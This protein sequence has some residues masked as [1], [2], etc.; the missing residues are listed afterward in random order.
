MKTGKIKIMKKTN[1]QLIIF[2]ATGDLAS[3]KLFP[4]IC[5][6]YCLKRLPDNFQIIGFGRT[7][8]TQEQFRKI[9]AENVDRKHQGKNDITALLSKHVFYFQGQY[10]DLEDFERLEKFCREIA[11]GRKSD[12]ITYFSVPPLLFEDIAQNLAVTLKRT[13]LDFKVVIEKPF[14]VSEKTAEHLF[15]KISANYDEPKVFLLDHFLG[16]RPIQSILKMR[17]ENNVINLMIKGNEIAKI[18]IEASEKEDVGKRVGYYDQV[19][20]IKDMVQSH[21]LQILALITMDIPASLSLESLQREKQNILSAIRFS[22][23]KE[24]VIIGQYEGY[25]ELKDVTKGSKTETYAA[26]RLNIDR[27]DWFNVPV[28]IKTGKKMN[29]SVTRATIE[30]KKM[31]FQNKKV[32]PNRLIFEMKPGEQLSLKLVQRATLKDP[33][34]KQTYE[35]VEL[36]QGLGCRVDFCLN[37]YAALLNDVIRGEHTYFLS[38]PEIV[39]AWNVTDKIEQSIKEKKVPL[40]IYK[41]KASEP[42]FTC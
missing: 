22:G 33:S 39:A 36:S 20:A 40:H 30:F 35:S 23:K 8:L 16:K 6:L 10:S 21:L 28:Y 4:A 24:D 18:N 42:D 27:R 12:Q 19:G 38:Y 34:A 2:G 41:P 9:F 15:N 37:D 14:G 25:S 32:E 13:A 26:L 31:P 5:E 7:P 3:L 1:L 29:R 17:L 11:G